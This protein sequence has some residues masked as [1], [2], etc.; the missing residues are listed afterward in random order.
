M[1]KVLVSGVSSTT[2]MRPGSPS[3]GCPTAPAWRATLFQPMADANIVVDMIIQNTSSRGLHRPDL[4]RAPRATSKRPWRSSRRW[5]PRSRPS[6]VLGD[7][8][9]A[10]VSIV[11]VGMRNHA[12][13]ATKMFAALANEGI[14][15]LMITTSEIKISCVIDD[16]YTRTG[17]A[18]P[19][20]RLR[21][22]P[23]ASPKKI[24]FARRTCVHCTGR[25]MIRPYRR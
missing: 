3:P 21:S 1:E 9:I 5:P 2:K 15:I 22:G 11:G 10:K 14:N 6:E 13:V 8:N 16:K 4:H 17:G 7:E 18:G 24:S 20:R 19:A 12:G 25:H 23:A